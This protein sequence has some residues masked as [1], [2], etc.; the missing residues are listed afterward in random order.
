MFIVMVVIALVVNSWRALFIGA[1]LYSVAMAAINS[2]LS[3]GADPAAIVAAT[4]L[5]AALGSAI[6]AG[7]F[8]IKRA[9]LD[10]RRPARRAIGEG[11]R[12]RY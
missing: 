8:A 4:L 9:L 1:G 2:A 7:L 5:H 12:P 11:P 6:G 3:P 10:R